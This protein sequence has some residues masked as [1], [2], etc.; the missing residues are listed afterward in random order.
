MKQ[1]KLYHTV[2]ESAYRYQGFTTFQE[3]AGVVRDYP[4]DE[5]VMEKARI[6]KINMQQ[7]AVDGYSVPSFSVTLRLAEDSNVRL[8]E[9]EASFH[10]N[11]FEI[12]DGRSKMAALTLL[13]AENLEQNTVQ[14]HIFILS[15]E[16]MDLL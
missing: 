16:N 11:E 6:H 1:L 9:E 7:Q 14:V 10:F 5:E 8:E 13:E 15:A 2:Q 12:R 3:L 4:F